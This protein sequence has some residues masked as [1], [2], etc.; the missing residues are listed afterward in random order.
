MKLE[1]IGVNATQAVITAA[2]CVEKLVNNKASFVALFADGIYGLVTVMKEEGK[3]IQ[4]IACDTTTHAFIDM[5]FDDFQNEMKCIKVETGRC[6]SKAYM[7]MQR[8]LM[9]IFVNQK[10]AICSTKNSKTCQT[11]LVIKFLHEVFH[12]IVCIVNTALGLNIDTATPAKCGKYIIYYEKVNDN[13]EVGN[14]QVIIG[15][16]GSFWEEQLFGYRI[17][18]ST[19][20]KYLVPLQG[21][22]VS[23]E[24]PKQ[25]AKINI[26]DEC[27]TLLDKL[28]TFCNT[29]DLPEQFK[30]L[31]EM[32]SSGKSDA[33]NSHDYDLMCVFFF[34]TIVFHNS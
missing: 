30:S 34:Y 4:E 19:K 6:N 23:L 20:K 7:Q 10:Y 8:P 17:L 31:R 27:I 26:S 13:Q 12:F 16:S 1:F 9:S 18:C 21:I 32:L 3:V 25:T 29:L 15:D 22:K 14:K 24:G 11:F 28:W 33:N 5:I 2:A